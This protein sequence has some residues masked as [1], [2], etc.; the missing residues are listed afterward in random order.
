MWR[1]FIDEQEFSTDENPE[2]EIFY[3][4]NRKI[5]LISSHLNGCSKM[6]TKT[7]DVKIKAPFTFPNAFTP[8]GDGLGDYFGP[9][10]KNPEDYQFNIRI[11]NRQGQLV[12]ES[13]DFSKKWDGKIRGTNKI[14]E[15]GVYCYQATIT[16]RYGNVDKETGNV[17]LLEP[18]N[19]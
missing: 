11:F 5:K 1:W 14:G 13:N 9:I 6:I 15:E 8:N 3:N 2:T 7:I 16:D 18:I 4:G 10:A 12:F 17:T 19:E